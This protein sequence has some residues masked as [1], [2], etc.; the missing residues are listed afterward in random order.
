M[1]QYHALVQHVLDTGVRK[2][3]RTGIDTLSAFGYHYTHDLANGFPLLTSKR[4]HWKSVVI[5]NLWFLSGQPH[6]HFLREY[7][8]KFWEPW[9]NTAGFVPS[10]YGNFWRRFPN[11]TYGIITAPQS[12]FAD[13]IEWVLAELLRNPNSRRMVVSAWHP[14]NAHNSLLPPCHVMFVLNT[15]PPTVKGGKYRLNLALMQRSCDI[16]LGVPFNLA[17]YAFIQ[18]LFAHLAGMEPGVFSHTLV[19]AHIYTAKPD[20]KMAEYDH[21]PGLREQLTRPVRKLPRLTISPDIKSLK[22]IEDIIVNRP[23][24]EHI[25]KTFRLDDY[26]PHPFISFKVAV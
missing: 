9:A 21:V 6:I 18:S 13:Q 23:P 10:A 24:E 14:G 7:G 25:L 15:T 2:E 26:K 5:E 1:Q 17:G 8:V 16:A 4:I 22:D 19:D 3:N 11:A 12:P 20:G